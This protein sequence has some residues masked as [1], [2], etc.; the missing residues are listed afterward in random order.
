VL[1]SLNVQWQEL[2]KRGDLFSERFKKN[3]LI[4]AVKGPGQVPRAETLPQPSW[5][6]QQ[7]RSP[8]KAPPQGAPQGIRTGDDEVAAA[9]GRAGGSRSSDG[10]GDGTGDGRVGAGA[11]QANQLDIFSGIH[12]GGKGKGREKAAEADGEE[13]EEEVADSEEVGVQKSRSMKTIEGNA[14]VKGQG[15]GS[16]AE[17]LPRPLMT[18]SRRHRSVRMVQEEE[19][20]EERVA[21]NAP[22][23]GVR[24]R[25]SRRGGGR[26]GAGAGG[27][28]WGGSRLCTGT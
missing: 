18:T 8:A 23:S 19:G 12:A 26:A 4:A 9:A 27:G 13:Q 3:I 16:R 17:E 11:R 21:G 6:Q 5:P 22:E 7:Q 14:K 25:R 15:Q 2:T 10:G 20:L 1:E 24:R 28:G